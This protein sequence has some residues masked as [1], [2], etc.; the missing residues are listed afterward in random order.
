MNTAT[1]GL[2]V[3]LV[4]GLALGGMGDFGAFFTV[5]VFGVVGYLAGKVIE[6]DIN[7]SDYIGQNR[8]RG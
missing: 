6:G 7:P 2:F 4:L 5:V 1:V 3:G 8:K